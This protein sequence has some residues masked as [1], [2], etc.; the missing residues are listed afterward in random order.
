MM[1]YQK[2]QV[3]VPLTHVSPPIVVNQGISLTS[4]GVESLK[5]VML[6][7]Q[8]TSVSRISKKTVVL[9]FTVANPYLQLFQRRLS[10]LE[11]AVLIKGERN[12]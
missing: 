11:G 1:Q 12:E 5:A 8:S 4:T 6:A 3:R 7:A 9:E 10:N 2:I